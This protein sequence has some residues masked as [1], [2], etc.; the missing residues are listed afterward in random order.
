MNVKKIKIQPQITVTSEIKEWFNRRGGSIGEQLM[1]AIRKEPDFPRKPD[2][3]YSTRI[4]KN[5][6]ICNFISTEG[7]PYHDFPLIKKA[8]KSVSAFLK[9]FRPD[10][11]AREIV[12][13]PLR[14]GLRIASMFNFHVDNELDF[15]ATVCAFEKLKK[16]HIPGE[17][18]YVPVNPGV[19]LGRPPQRIFE[20][21]HALA[22]VF[23]NPTKKIF[24]TDKKVMLL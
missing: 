13:I 3:V 10:Y 12:V 24:Y 19:L 7:Y 5:A 15:M 17:T 20:I 18:L 11:P 8:K 22:S 21:I 9:D 16:A 2:K 4:F 1:A 14:P 6:L 23:I